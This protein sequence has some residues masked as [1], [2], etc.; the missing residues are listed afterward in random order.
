M[1]RN[2]FFLV[3]V[4]LA[5]CSAPNESGGAPKSA[6]GAKYTI[7]LIPKGLGHQFWL[8]VKQGGEAAGKELG[9]E[10]IWT[11]PAKETEVAR[12][13]SIVQ[14]M[15]SRPVN[16]I[17]MAA[18]DANALVD[19]IKSAMD[20]GVPVVTIDSGVN[21]D[22]PV[23]FVATDNIK[24]AEIAAATLSD[25]IGG[26]GKVGLLPF[27]PG[28]ATSEMREQGF[29]QGLAKFPNVELVSTL[30]TNS[31]VAKAL[32]VTSD[33]LTAHPDLKGIFAAN[34]PGAIGAI[35]AL[36]AAGKAGA[37]KI[38]AFDASAEELDALRRGVIHALIVQDPYRMGHDGVKAAIDHLEGRPIEK[39]I[40]TGVTVVTLD[41]LDSPEVQKLVGS[42]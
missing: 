18:C 12:Q 15:V 38:V 2:L 1:R 24:G 37:V 27:V 10:I 35:Q 13:I 26:E 36:E 22:V 11:G 29:K 41:N 34:E 28:A 3:A 5:A 21:S 33:M 9:V 8:T 39:R 16:A 19:T 32:A 42:K 31:D 14:D 20:A 6:S 40:D 4:L 17:V 30:H 25:L 7:A 23:S